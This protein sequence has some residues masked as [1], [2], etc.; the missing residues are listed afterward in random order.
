MAKDWDYFDKFGGIIKRYMPIRGEGGTLASQAVTAVNKLV[1]KW[2]NDGD[3]FDNTYNLKGW[4]NDISTYANWLQ[5]YIPETSD[6]LGRIRTINR[7]G[8]YE[9]LLADLANLVLDN[10]RIKELS[11]K[12]AEGSIYTKTG[13]YRYREYGELDDDCDWEEW[14]EEDD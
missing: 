14:D 13:P 5:Y 1:Y 8:E 2:Y 7:D 10:D 9:D 4:W 3:V 12:P 11:K 6:I